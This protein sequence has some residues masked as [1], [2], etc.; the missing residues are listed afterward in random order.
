M[1]LSDRDVFFLF[2]TSNSERNGSPCS[3]GAIKLISLTATKA[4]MDL[5]ESM[6]RTG[7]VM[8]FNDRMIPFNEFTDFIGLPEIYAQEEKYGVRRG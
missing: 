1:P 5:M 3:R 2:T 8:E 7:D 6:V 4:M